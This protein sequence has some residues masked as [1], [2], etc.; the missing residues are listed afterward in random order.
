MASFI[1][2]VSAPATP[3][4]S[5]VTGSPRLADHHAAQ[6]LAHVVQ[7]GSQR[8]DGHDLAGNGDVEAGDAGHALFVRPLADVIWRSMRSLISITRFQVMVDGSIPAGKRIF[9]PG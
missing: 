2:T 9:C 3:R 6:A 8:Q 7:A 5:A 1:S 4:S